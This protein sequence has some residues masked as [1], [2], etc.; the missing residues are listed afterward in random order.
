LLRPADRNRVTVLRQPVQEVPLSHFGELGED[1]ILFI[2]SSHVVKVGS[3]VAHL[4]GQVLPVLRP[5]VVIHVHDVFWPFEY[6]LQWLRGG[7]AW[8]ELYMLRAFLQNNDRYQIMFFA[9]WFI[10]KHASL[11]REE[12]PSLAGG[13]ASLWLRKTG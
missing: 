1:D 3:D 12:T 13:S 11:V 4:L 6:P 2:D 5:G 8:N 10:R 7:R 9:D